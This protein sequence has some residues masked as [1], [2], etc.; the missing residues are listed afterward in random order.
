[1]RRVTRRWRRVFGAQVNYAINPDKAN[2]FA[3]TLLTAEG[4]LLAPVNIQRD[5]CPPIVPSNK[6]HRGQCTASASP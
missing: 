1:M 5:Y 6:R 3:R 4:R 2:E